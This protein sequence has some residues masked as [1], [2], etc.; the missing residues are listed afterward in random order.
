L[1]RIE[2]KQSA[3]EQQVVWSPELP[4]GV[5]GF[6]LEAGKQQA[7]GKMILVE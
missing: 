1:D 4:D 2:Q 7:Y 6:R 3:G 5:Y